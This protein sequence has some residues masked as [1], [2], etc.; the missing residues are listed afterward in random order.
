MLC[1][2]LP[3]NP[4][5]IMESHKK[6]SNGTQELCAPQL[7]EPSMDIDPPVYTYVRPLTEEDKLTSPD[8]RKMLQLPKNRDIWL[9]LP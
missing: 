2:N 1:K 3:I 5:P 9:T 6:R 4:N 8:T 7:T